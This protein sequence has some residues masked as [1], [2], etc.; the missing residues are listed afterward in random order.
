MFVS[1]IFKVHP[2]LNSTFWH[3]FKDMLKWVSIDLFID[4]LPNSFLKV[5]LE[6]YFISTCMYIKNDSFECFLFILIFK[7][8]KFQMIA[9]ECITCKEINPAWFVHDVHSTCIVM[10]RLCMLAGLQPSINY[11]IITL[12]VQE[13]IS[14]P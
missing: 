12:H 3:C 4:K 5:L 7:L 2:G 1:R 11:C 13:I 14:I 9:T 6:L 8:I 10:I